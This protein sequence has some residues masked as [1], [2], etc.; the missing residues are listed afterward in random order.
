MASA[1]NDISQFFAAEVPSGDPVR[2]ALA[3]A[4]IAFPDLEPERYL[5]QLDAMRALASPRVMAATAGGGRALALIQAMRLDLGMRGNTERYYDAANSF[6]NVVLE[7]RMGLPI[8]LSLILVAIGRRLGLAVDGAGFPGHFM[9]RYEDEGGTWYL[10]PFHGAVMIPEDVP[11]YITKL[12]GQASI[13]LN[14]SHFAPV[15]PEAWALRILNNL[16]AVYINAGDFGMLTKV[17]ALMLVLEPNRHDLW[18]ELGLVEYRRGELSGAARALRRYFF[19][20]GYISMSAPHADGPS[21]LP[22]LEGDDK[23]LWSLLEEI[24]VA[25]TRW[26]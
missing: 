10:D 2:L 11:A 23:Q 9:A 17:L 4:R 7:R 24:E 12:F 21:A 6:L 3:I 22:A 19:L 16:R 26:N 25:R 13:S 5:L 15:A 18:Q 20:Q 8:M 14:E 1:S